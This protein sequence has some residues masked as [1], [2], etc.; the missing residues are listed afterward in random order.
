MQGRMVLAMHVAL[1]DRIKNTI[2]GLVGKYE[3]EEVL[4]D[5]LYIDQTIILKWMLNRV[6]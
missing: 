5:D 1:M 6:Q 3:E 2:S 4:L